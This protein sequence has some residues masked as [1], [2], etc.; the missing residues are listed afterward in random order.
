MMTSSVE[1]FELFAELALALGG[2]SGVAA[3]FGGRDREFR[4]IERNRLTAVFLF[5]AISL[6]EALL[7]IALT[8]A[9]ISPD[10]TYSITCLVSGLLLLLLLGIQF[11]P[12]VRLYRAGESTTSGVFLL[13]ALLFFVSCGSM[14]FWAALYEHE[15]WPLVVGMSA[16]LMMGL[17]MFARLLL[18]SN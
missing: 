5:A 16:Q 3:A 17:W 15:S 9:G 10:Q 8:H 4:E 14:F 12:V 13:V 18:R 11:P 7:V 1:T 2:F 6:G